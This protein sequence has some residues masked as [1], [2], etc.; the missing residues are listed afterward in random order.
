MKPYTTGTG[1]HILVHEPKQCRG[2]DCVIHRPSRHH[3]RDW[4]THWRQD[5]GIMERICRH[6]VGHPDPDDM[7]YQ[8][9]RDASQ[10]DTLSVHGCDGCCLDPHLV[11][12]AMEQVGD[13]SRAECVTCGAWSDETPARFVEEQ[14]G[15]CARIAASR[16]FGVGVSM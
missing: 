16:R 1:Q 2:R 15:V 12:P 6:Q 13:A 3:M 9:E 8:R 7:A 10:A 4:P 5:A 11:R 14:C